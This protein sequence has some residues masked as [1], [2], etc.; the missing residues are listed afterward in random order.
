[1]QNPGLGYTATG[2]NLLAQRRQNRQPVPKGDSVRAVAIPDPMIRR[3]AS[4][5]IVEC[6]EAPSA[7]RGREERLARRNKQ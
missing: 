5:W 3:T 6:G 7:E 2:N 1:M 4:V